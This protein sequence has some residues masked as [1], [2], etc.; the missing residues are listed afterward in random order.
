MPVHGAMRAVLLCTTL[1][2]P[3]VSGCAQRSEAAIAP[4]APDGAVLHADR[5]PR[6]SAGRAAT[7]GAAHAHAEGLAGLLLLL[8]ARSGQLS[9]GGHA[10]SAMAL[11]CQHVHRTASTDQL[12]AVPGRSRG[13]SLNAS[14]CGSQG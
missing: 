2:I 10:L 4:I 14:G 12:R 5:Q 9:S 1:L 8:A 13:V 11:H 7:L 3:F 6:A